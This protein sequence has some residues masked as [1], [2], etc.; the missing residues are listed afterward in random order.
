[1]FNKWKGYDYE[2]I[3]KKKCYHFGEVNIF[4]L[5]PISCYDINVDK[6]NKLI[7]EKD[8][9]AWLILDLGCL[10][11]VDIDKLSN[12]N[13]YFEP[14]EDFLVPSF[15]EMNNIVEFVHE[16]GLKRNVLVSCM[17]GH[18]R[19]G[20]VLAVWAGLNGISNPVEYIRNNYCKEAVESV[21]QEMFVNL[22][23]KYIKN[24]SR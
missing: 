20:I 5:V 16:N 2:Y 21:T 10:V 3:V 18:G 7:D 19:T 23:L 17:A 11:G 22:Y 8:V 14:V 1:L 6:I 13:I 4:N 9:K 24:L 12:V 15:K